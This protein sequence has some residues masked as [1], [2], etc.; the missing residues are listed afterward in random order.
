M[1]RACRKLRLGQDAAGGASLVLCD[2]RAR[3]ARDDGGPVLIAH[4]TPSLPCEPRKLH[5]KRVHESDYVLTTCGCPW[6]NNPG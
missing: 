6:V 1:R 5:G 4:P 3:G 2:L